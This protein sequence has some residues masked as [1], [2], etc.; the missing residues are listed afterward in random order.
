MNQIAVYLLGNPRI[1]VGDRSVNSVSAKAWALLAY[2]ALNPL[3]QPRERLLGL[4]WAESAEAAARK[5]LRNLLWSLRKDMGAEALIEQADHIS[6]SPDV[7]V[8]VAAFES[9]A[10]NQNQDADSLNLFR[11]GLLEGISLREA[12]EFELWLTTEQERLAQQYSRIL[13]RH[14]RQYE[15][16]GEWER[17]SDLAFRGLQHYPLDERVTMS[18]MV[19][20]ARQGK[21]TEALAQY[22]RFKSLLAE[23]LGVEPLPESLAV[24][25]AIRNHTLQ[26]GIVEHVRQMPPPPRN[27]VFVGREGELA[28]ISEAFEQSRAGV[29]VVLLHGETGIGKTRLLQEW[30]DSLPG[31]V[32]KLSMTALAATQ[33][34]PLMPIAG[35]FHTSAL[36]A[37]FVP[38]S[39]VNP[40]WLTEMTRLIPEIRLMMPGLPDLPALPY[41]DE[42]RRLFQALVEALRGLNTRHLVLTLDDMH[43]ADST[44]IEWLMY[45]TH[46]FRE[47]PLLLIGTYR[48]DEISPVLHGAVAHWSRA[49]TLEQVRLLPLS[50]DAIT[51]MIASLGDERNREQVFHQSGGNPYYAIEMVRADEGRIPEALVELITSRLN[52]LPEIAQQVLQVASVLEPY[53]TFDL[54]YQASGR[55]EDE[56]LD[57]LDVLVNYICLREQANGYAFYHPLTAALIRQNMSQT[58]Q[59][60]VHRRVFQ[61]LEPLY[62]D[63]DHA[64]AGKLFE[65]AAQAGDTRHAAYYAEQAAHYAM[66]LAARREAA[67][68]YRQALAFEPTP[69]RQIQLA[70]ALQPLGELAEARQLMEQAREAYQREGD[71][72]MLAQVVVDIGE[73]YLQSGD[74]EAAIGWMEQMIGLAGLPPETRARALTVYGGALLRS[75][76]GLN[77]AE[78]ALSQAA[79]IGQAHQLTAIAAYATFE[80]GNIRA[81]QGDL[82]G[83]IEALQQSQRLAHSSEDYYREILTYNN[84]AYYALLNEAIDEAERT[85]RTAF[86]LVESFEIWLPL[87]YLY[88]TQGEIALYRQQ[89]DEAESCFLKGLPEAEKR[90]NTEQVANYQ[91]NLHLVARGR[92]DLAQ[93]QVWLDTARATLGEHPSPYLQTLLKLWQIELDLLAGDNQQ[94]KQGVDQLQSG[95]QSERQ[96]LLYQRLLRLESRTSSAR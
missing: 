9:A 22:E 28:R 72:K 73:S 90:G 54:L 86:Q 1:Q 19:A 30:L 61:T 32:T 81:Q 10:Q 5:N 34:L 12:P 3:A 58:R 18:L 57:A 69:S 83:A 13:S 88:S 77:R 26:N 50:E 76:K 68:F 20:L 2:L 17:V 16:S 44:T 27:T 39:P 6:L 84:C 71:E 65:H 64:L 15:L 46:Q 48:T 14:I 85:I 94:A 75:G 74:P 25:E 31:G 52:R 78:E 87:Q 95:W 49:G 70:R 82:P 51:N 35:L 41:E 59:R 80:I 79:A 89:W 56:V 38:M 40:I 92:H 8:D 45:L 23:R 36:Q 24:Y 60:I 66:T 29:R 67:A 21:R 63:H 62:R 42:Q 4:L 96:G 37:L 43:W 33:N 11:G 55:S 91:A 93:A 53:I 47:H 7:W